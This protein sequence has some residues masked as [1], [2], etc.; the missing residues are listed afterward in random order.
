[1]VE[2]EK[3]ET[4]DKYILK[5]FTVQKDISIGKIDDEE[6]FTDKGILLEILNKIDRIEKAVA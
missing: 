1:M 3:K 6:I 5:E 2:K 4:T